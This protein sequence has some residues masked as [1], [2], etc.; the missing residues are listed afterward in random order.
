M[1]T[2]NL[3]LAGPSIPPDKWQLEIIEHHYLY[4]EWYEAT[5]SVMKRHTDQG[6]PVHVSKS[7]LDLYHEGSI[8]YD[9]AGIRIEVRIKPCD[10]IVASPKDILETGRI[11]FEIGN[12]HI[13]IFLNEANEIMAAYD[14]NLYSLLA[15]GGFDLKIENKI[16]HPDQMVKAFGNAR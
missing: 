16:L 10:V 4:I 14:A 11:C 8:I 3:L 1:D 5:T 2:K 7:S 13:P 9:D 15:S 6:L 12:Q